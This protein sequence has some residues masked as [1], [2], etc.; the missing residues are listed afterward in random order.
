VAGGSA[1]GSAR[2]IPP[3]TGLGEGVPAAGAGDA[4][5]LGERET[6]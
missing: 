1:D 3:A 2:A 6:T 4:D 5:G